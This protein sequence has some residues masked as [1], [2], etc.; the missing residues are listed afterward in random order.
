MP[1]AERIGDARRI[2]ALIKA[3]QD[4]RYA[5]TFYGR[6][7]PSVTAWRIRQPVHQPFFITQGSIL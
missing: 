4:E 7:A 6:N 1:E 2:Q 5:P 3:A